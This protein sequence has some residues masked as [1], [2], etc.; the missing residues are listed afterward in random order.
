MKMLS[1]CVEATASSATGSLSSC[2]CYSFFSSLIQGY[3]AH[4]EPQN[5]SH[6]RGCCFGS[7]RRHA[8]SIRRS[9]WT[10]DRLPDV[11][12]AQV[13]QYGLRRHHEGI[14][15]GRVHSD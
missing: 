4:D 11:S 3:E 15:C 13:D 6:A 12:C 5:V 8:I 1:I 2:R 9:A 7:P 14:A 10:A